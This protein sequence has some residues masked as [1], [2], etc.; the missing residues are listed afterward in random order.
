MKIFAGIGAKLLARK[1][2]RTPGLVKGMSQEIIAAYP[3]IERGLKLL[4]IHKHTS[5]IKNRSI[6]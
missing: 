4:K 2:A 3:L 1:L 5:P 6:D